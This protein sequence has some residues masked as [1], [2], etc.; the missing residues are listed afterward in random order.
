MSDISIVVEQRRGEESRGEFRERASWHSPWAQL[1]SQRAFVG[2]SALLFLASVAATIEW[3]ESMTAMREMPMP[4]G[5]TMSMAWMRMPG[6]TWT[7]AAATFLGMWAVMMAAMMLPCFI[8][9]L[10]RYRQAVYAAGEVATADEARLGWLTA[11]VGAAYFFMWT[12]F[13]LVVFPVGAALATIEMHVPALARAVPPAIGAVV[14]IAGALQFTAW[15]AR[16][17]A[18]GPSGSRTAASGGAAAC[19]L[20]SIA[21]TAAQG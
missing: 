7:G 11:L 3:C 16:H 4:G 17:L 6:E 18:A 20:A 1:S 2:I 12:M 21:A 5:W 8:P 15:K 14:L 13:G 19:G 10:W 9:T